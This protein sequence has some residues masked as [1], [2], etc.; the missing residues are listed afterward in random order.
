M[1]DA[2]LDELVLYQVIVYV[3]EEPHVLSNYWDLHF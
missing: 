3:V 1:S 2:E